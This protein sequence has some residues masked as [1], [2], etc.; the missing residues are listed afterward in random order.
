MIGPFEVRKLRLLIAPSEASNA[1][2]ENA[3]F[4]ARRIEL[5]ADEIR[6]WREYPRFI[7]GIH[8]EQRM[9]ERPP[10]LYV[11]MV[12]DESFALKAVEALA[13]F[14]RKPKLNIYVHYGAPD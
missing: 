9:N 6:A 4:W 3:Q 14:L 10:K 8:V 7:L 11:E 12:A 2:G 13:A 1:Q 5:A